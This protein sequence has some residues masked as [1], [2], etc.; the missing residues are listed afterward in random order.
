MMAGYEQSGLTRRE[1]CLQRNIP[2][3][4]FDYYR[5]RRKKKARRPTLVAVKVDP[6]APPVTSVMTVILTNGR[7]VEVAG[8]FA[9]AELARLL[10]VAER[11]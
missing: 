11:V 2:L 1:Y 10:R 7:R 5:H 3:T 6:S 4:T 9:E 8:G